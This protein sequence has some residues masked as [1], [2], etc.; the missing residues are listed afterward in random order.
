[1]QRIKHFHRYAGRLFLAGIPLSVLSNFIG[2]SV[3]S[4]EGGLDSEFGQL[5]S[6]PLLGLLAGILGILSVACYALGFLGYIIRVRREQKTTDEEMPDQS[7][8]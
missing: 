5:V 6:L 8:G 3:I 1:M 2:R 4:P 7:D